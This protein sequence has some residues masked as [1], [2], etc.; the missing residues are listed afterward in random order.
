M[1]LFFVSKLAEHVVTSCLKQQMNH[2]FY[3]PLQSTN[4]KGH[5]TEIALLKIIDH[6]LRAMDRKE[7]TRV[8]LLD[9]SAAFD[10]HGQSLYPS[11]ATACTPRS[12][13]L[14]TCLAHTSYLQG[15]TQI[16]HI[17]GSTSPAHD[18]PQ[19]S[20][21][22]PLLFCIYTLPLGNIVWKHRIKYH[23]CA[24]NTQLYFT[25]PPP[26]SAYPVSKLEKCTTEMC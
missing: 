19:G 12:Q 3:E 14:C 11:S 24:D 7:C 21:L 26:S 6:L 25:P 16:V 20:V 5:S 13:Q 2:D 15:G 4:Q 9:L 1:G 23:F 8:A 10:M 22:G 17:N 18:V